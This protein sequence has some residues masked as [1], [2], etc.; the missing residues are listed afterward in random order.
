MP[1]HV[2]IEKGAV[3][4]ARRIE[5]DLPPRLRL[6]DTINVLEYCERA[7]RMVVGGIGRASL[8]EYDY[9]GVVVASAE[10][11]DELGAEEQVVASLLMDDGSVDTAAAPVRIFRPRLEFGDTPGLAIL[12]DRG[13]RGPS[14]PIRLRFSGFGDVSLRC[15][16]S[17][18]GRTVSRSVPAI[19]WAPWQAMLRLGTGASI[20][21]VEEIADLEARILGENVKL[22]SRTEVAAPFEPPLDDLL[23]EFWY[24]DVLGNE[25]GPIQKTIKIVDRRGAGAGA[26]SAVPLDIVA[27]ES[28]AYR[29]V[30]GM[31]IPPGGLRA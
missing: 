30:A 3:D 8:C 14:I 17:V 5:V 20:A 16:C 31:N 28:G 15:R 23:V 26:G 29:D 27:D 4:S 21:I 6:V 18:G 22:E 24:S 11:F 10:P 13:P 2:R 9:F 7:G 12:E 25:Y 1:V 19:G